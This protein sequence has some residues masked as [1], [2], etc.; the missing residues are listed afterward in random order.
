MFSF[1]TRKKTSRVSNNP[2]KQGACSQWLLEQ[3]VNMVMANSCRE[4]S[5][6]GQPA[7]HFTYY[8]TLDPSKRSVADLGTNSSYG[9]RHLPY[10]SYPNTS[11]DPDP[12]TDVLTFC[13]FCS[14][15]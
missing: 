3:F 8:L 2:I 14:Q 13:F 9:V 11:T 15:S 12:N 1:V 5:L 7:G 4:E 6:F 10:C